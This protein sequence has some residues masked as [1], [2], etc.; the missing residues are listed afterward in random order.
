MFFFSKC[1][2]N[3]SKYLRFDLYAIFKRSQ[4]I[5]LD[6][7]IFEKAWIKVREYFWPKNVKFVKNVSKLRKRK[8]NKLMLLA[9]LTIRVVV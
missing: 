6:W 2:K 3:I 7:V 5:V 8:T 1:V 9:R 4:E